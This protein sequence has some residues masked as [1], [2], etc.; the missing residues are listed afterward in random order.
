MQIK[1]STARQFGVGDITQPDP[2]V[3][4]GTQLLALLVDGYFKDAP[5]DEQNRTLFAIAAYGMGAGALQWCQSKTK[6]AK[7]D[8]NLWFNNVEQVAS[9]RVGQETPRAIRTIYKY[10]VAYK[11][12]EEASAARKAAVGTNKTPQGAEAH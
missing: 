10:Y 6:E 7:L 3:H 11:L 9:A 1:P 12:L 4:A 5:L 8:P 2:N